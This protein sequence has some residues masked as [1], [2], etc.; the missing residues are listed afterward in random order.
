MDAN[1][2]TVIVS[3]V[4]ALV[5]PVVVGWLVHLRTRKSEERKA[6]ADVSRLNREHEVS[7]SGVVLSWAQRLEAQVER[8][9]RAKELAEAENARLERENE[10]LREH[11]RLLI[12][13]LLAAGLTPA[14]EPPK[15]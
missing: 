13:Q 5:G 7:V 9:T 15:A 6:N 12:A 1:T 10:A 3:I 8:T 2:A 14:P 11:N 4:T